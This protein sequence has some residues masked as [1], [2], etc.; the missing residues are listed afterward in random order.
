M[1]SLAADLRHA[2]RLLRKNPVFTAIAIAALALGIGANTAI[3]SVVNAV[4]LR[5]LPYPEPDRIVFLLRQYPR[6]TGNSVSV[7]KFNVWKQRAASVDFI[8][9]F[10]F[11]SL[12][13]T[14]G[15]GESAEQVSSV[16]VTADYF[17]LFGA[18]PA[19]GRT[20]L[21]EEDR[22]GGQRAA[23]LSDRIW[24]RRFG[25]D[26]SIVG[27]SITLG[28]E[29]VTVVGVL[30]PGFQP[31]PAAEVWVPLQADPNSTNQGHYLR[32][33][34]RLKPGVTLEAANAQLKLVGEE[35][36]R[37]YPKWMDDKETVGAVPMQ[38]EIVGDVRPA[39][40]ILTGA[41]SLV[42]LIACANVANLLLARAAAR[43]REIAIRCAVGASRWRLIRQLLSE[44]VMLSI[45][46]GVLGLLLGSWGVRALLLAS[47]GEIPR[48]GDLRTVSTFALLDARVLAFTVA[49]AVLTGVVFGLFP[50]LQL[51]NP[52]VHSTL[53][54]AGGRTSSGLRHNRARG[55]L[56]VSEIALALVLV[57]GAALLIRSFVGLR[58]VDPGFDARNVLTLQIS[59]TN[60]RYSTTAQMENFERQ[61]AQRIEGLPGV[62]AAAPAVCLPVQNYG[63]DLPFLIE[64]KPPAAGSLY[65]G[66]EFWRYVGPHYFEAFRIP[67]LRGRVF[68]EH[69]AMKSA[70]V[71]V[72]N[73]A[74]AK[75]YWPKEDPIGARIIIGKGLGPQFEEGP[76]Q[77]VGIVG[78]V[79]EGGLNREARPVMYIPASQ[80]TDG[81][82]RFANN[83]IPLSWVIRTAVDPLTL[84][85]AV[86][87]EL[88]AL[89]PTLPVAR[90][91]TME[92]VVREA[93]ARENFNMLLLTIFAG[94]ALL[95]AAI[96]IY[97]VMSYAVEQRAHEIGI[98]MALGAEHADVV[99]LFVRQGALLAGIGVI[100]GLGAAWGLTRLLGRLLFGVSASDPATFAVVAGLLAAVAVLASYIPARRAT[101]VDPVISLRYE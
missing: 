50:A 15:L 63:I 40:L 39:L 34:A 97:G 16:H 42:L 77:I 69:D 75:K 87:R 29:P 72:I 71:A 41:V 7:P 88:L 11:A 96:G 32:V 83:I 5:P 58:H 55:L 49:L 82:T 37:L 76:R 24:K 57:V 48:L 21:S 66:D 73:E 47:P 23:V 25:A 30:A 38:K 80:L 79:R 85:Q 74:M 45:L 36:R 61:G 94:V 20:F 81:L 65:N 10:D 4:L 99:R 78:N 14:L 8:S 12:P 95:L 59:M 2:L 3:F 93:T 1:E 60:P 100:I 43:Q 26:P 89:D 9:A 13:L 33:A 6:G 62:L 67:M 53:K 98:R 28:G 18:A 70:P 86:Q 17:R 27:R 46:G 31:D 52:D 92:Q 44:S 64:G 101:R 51:S 54:E 22:P 56:V 68:N 91:R 19:I 84:S 90:F 35:F